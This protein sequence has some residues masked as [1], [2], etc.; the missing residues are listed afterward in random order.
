M[1]ELDK[2]YGDHV[3]RQTFLQV[4]S[5]FSP[6]RRAADGTVA[7]NDI[8]DQ[9]LLAGLILASENRRVSYLGVALQCRFDFSQLDAISTQFDL[10]IDRIKELHVPIGQLSTKMSGSVQARQEL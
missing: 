6:P 10:V 7:G 9:P 8:G 4:L 5:Q 2:H 3:F 1:K